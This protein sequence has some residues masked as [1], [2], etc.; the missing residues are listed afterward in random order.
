MEILS[1]HYPREKKDPFYINIR[2]PIPQKVQR[3][4][5]MIQNRGEYPLD[6]DNLGDL[7][8]LSLSQEDCE[9]AP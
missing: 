4:P 8:S 2:N 5:N 6:W 3:I 1:S 7:A 9:D